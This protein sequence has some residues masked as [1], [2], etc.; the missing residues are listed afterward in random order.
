MLGSDTDLI[1][2]DPDNPRDQVWIVVIDT[3]RKCGR[4]GNQQNPAST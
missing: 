3:P 4:C 1:C 2:V